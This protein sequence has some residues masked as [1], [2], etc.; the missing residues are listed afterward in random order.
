MVTRD[1]DAMLAEKAGV[2]PTFK[3]GGQEFALRAKLPYTKWNK[4]IEQ[5]RSDDVD[6]DEASAN[7]FRAVLI[8]ADRERF[9]ELMA[10][11]DDDDD[12]ENVIDLSQMDD[13]TEWI[14]ETFTGKTRNS[15]GSSSDGVNG[16][17]QPPNVVSLSSRTATG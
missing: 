8:K 12:D 13:L 2:R 4:L 14:M 15:S 1:F 17:G 16:T 9:L 3:I 7:F 5:M 11:E 6:A 10:K